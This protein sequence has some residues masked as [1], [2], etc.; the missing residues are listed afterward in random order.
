MLLTYLL[1]P[2]GNRSSLTSTLTALPNQTFTYDADDRLSSDTYD[3]NGNTLASGGNIFAYD[4]EDRLTQFDASVQLSYDGDGNRIVR[5]QGGSTTRYL[6]DDLTPTGYPQVAE[7][8]V[9]GALTAQYTYGRLRISQNRGGVVSYYGYDA[10]ASVREL[11][12]DTGAI[13]DTYDYDAFGNTVAQTGSTVNE[14]L[15][16]GEQF[17]SSLGLYY[18][19]ARYYNPLSGSGLV[20]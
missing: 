3:A 10:G 1:D 16:R 6:V 17:D 8:I 18:L 19:R 11:F 2:V 9:S 14:F 12:S 4:F 20:P 13:T 7:E 15:Y 5:T